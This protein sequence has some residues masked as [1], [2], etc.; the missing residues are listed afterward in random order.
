MADPAEPEAGL[1]LEKELGTSTLAALREFLLEQQRA[2]AAADE[3][4]A[5]P[6]AAGALFYNLGVRLENSCL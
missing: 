2:D 5:D 6:F 4:G 1:D 3:G